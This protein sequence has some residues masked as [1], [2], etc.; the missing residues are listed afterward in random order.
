MA[1]ELLPYYERELAYIRRLGAEFAKANPKIAGRLRIGPESVEDPH[2][3]RLIEA[4]AFL[5]ARVRFKLDDD[6]PELTDGLLSVLYPHYL[7]PL[8]SMAIVQFAP[9]ADL[10]DCYVVPRQTQL[11]TEPIE[12]EPCR[13]RTCYPTPLWPILVRGA[14]LAGR[15]IDAPRHPA[16]S[17][18]LSVLRLSLETINPDA[19]FSALS[20]DSLRFFLTGQS[21]EIYPLYQLIMNDCLGIAVADSAGD[22]A[23]TV[24]GPNAVTPVGFALDEGMLDYPARAFPGYRLL[25]EFFAFPQKFLFFELTGLKQRTSRQASRTIEIFFYLKRADPDLEPAVKP[26]M[27]ALGCTPIVNLFRQIAEPIQIT[28]LESEYRVVPDAR[29]P[30]AMEVYSI[31]DVTAISPDGEGRRFDPFYWIKHAQDREGKTAFWQAMRRPAGFT[32]SASEVF[33]KLVDLDHEPTSPSG[34]AL[35]AKTTC[36]NRNLPNKLPF[37]GG[38]PKLALSEGDAPLKRISCLT[39]PTPTLRPKLRKGTFWR[40]ISHLNLNHLTLTGGE[41]GAEALREILRLYDFRDSPESQAMIDGVA[42]LGARG[43]AR[44]S[45]AGAVSAMSRGVEVRIEFDESKFTGS[46][47]FLL[48]SV[49]ERFLA[50]YSS[51]NSFTQLVATLKGREGVLRQWPPRAGDKAIL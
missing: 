20:P 1:D 29:R 24:L 28:H 14:R 40:L 25:T 12:G 33:V 26:E 3:S 21:Q 50:L 44:R 47:A 9:Q 22:P 30:N 46:N 5:N 43:V 13:F 41:N 45:P 17:K 39:A 34:W 48:A 36:L 31:D 35:T 18:T 11:E 15:P 16:F 38:Q 27:F 49:L 32:D 8:P 7:A 37:G 51:I 19:G 42:L 23:P 6:F 10:T 4:V 2:V